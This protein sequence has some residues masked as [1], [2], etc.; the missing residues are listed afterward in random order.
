M[1]ETQITA[2]RARCRS[3]T[4][5][6]IETTDPEVHVCRGFVSGDFV[7]NGSRHALNQ[8]SDDH[9]LEH[10]NRIGKFAGGLVGITRSDTAMD[11]DTYMA[12]DTRVIF[13]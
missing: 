7:V 4:C 12:H 5:M 10:I 2:S 13:G 1:G 9:G 8:L 3:R 6:A 11:L